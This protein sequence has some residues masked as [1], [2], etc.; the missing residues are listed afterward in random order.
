MYGT[1][2]FFLQLQQTQIKL[3]LFYFLLVNSETTVK[4]VSSHYFE[5]VRVKILKKH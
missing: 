3:F 1:K 5:N 2:L 4:M